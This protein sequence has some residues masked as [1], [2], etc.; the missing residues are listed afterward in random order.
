MS[1]AIDAYHIVLT[2][3]KIHIDN[4]ATGCVNLFAGT[5]RGNVVHLLMT[6]TKGSKEISAN[7]KKYSEWEKNYGGTIDGN[8]S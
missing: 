2:T 8:I 4:K 3:G 1:K 5:V 6:F 7:R